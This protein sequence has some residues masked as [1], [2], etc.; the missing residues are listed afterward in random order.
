MIY[1]CVS[2]I[3]TLLL[4]DVARFALPLGPYLFESTKIRFA[5]VY[6][7]LFKNSITV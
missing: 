4:P 1:E 2:F 3:L 5:S 7:H 6:V